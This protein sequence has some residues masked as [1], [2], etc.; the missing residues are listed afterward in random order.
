[1][2][3]PIV[4]GRMSLGRNQATYGDSSKDDTI[5]L[6]KTLHSLGT[7]HLHYKS[8]PYVSSKIVW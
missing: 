7:L 2:T 1:M 3:H 4:I 5:K 8:S 6:L